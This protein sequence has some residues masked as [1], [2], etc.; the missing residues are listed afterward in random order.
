MVMQEVGPP[1]KRLEQGRVNQWM[2]KCEQEHLGHAC[3][4]LR[5]RPGPRSGVRSGPPMRSLTQAREVFGIVRPR[6]VPFWG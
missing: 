5:L 1:L 6:P 4:T 2:A 3:D